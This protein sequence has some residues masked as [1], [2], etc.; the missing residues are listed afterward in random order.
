MKKIKDNKIIDLKNKNEEEKNIELGR[1]S[2]Q[3]NK[4]FESRNEN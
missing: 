2:K 1:I 4:I 3:I